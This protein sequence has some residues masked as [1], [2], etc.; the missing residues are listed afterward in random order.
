MH[1]EFD[2]LVMASEVFPKALLA[3]LA[4][5]PDVSVGDCAVASVLPRITAQTNKQNK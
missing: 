1:N 4:A 3:I 5:E 2:E